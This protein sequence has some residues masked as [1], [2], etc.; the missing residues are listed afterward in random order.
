MKKFIFSIGYWLLHM[1]WGIITFIPGLF[2]FIVFLILK[3][4]IK[5]FKYSVVVSTD[6]MH[7]CGFSLGPFIFVAKDC[8]NSIDTLSHEHGHGIQTLFFGPLMIFI[9]SIPSAIRF[10]FRDFQLNSL[11]KKLKN[12]EITLDEYTDFLTTRPKYDDI[13]FEHQATQ[14][15]KILIKN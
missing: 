15:G 4:D 10:W 7:G 3:S 9:V 11:A 6:L 1:T 2:T 14:I 8:E 12:D 5:T 13:W